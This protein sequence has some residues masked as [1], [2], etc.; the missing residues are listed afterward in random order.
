[1]M[2]CWLGPEPGGPGNYVE[3]PPSGNV[4]RLLFTRLRHTRW[5]QPTFEDVS[6]GRCIISSRSLLLSAGV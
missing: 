5:V 1:M 6:E 2:T 3:T 4:L